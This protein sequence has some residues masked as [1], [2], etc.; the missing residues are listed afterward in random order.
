MSSRG[1]RPSPRCSLGEDVRVGRYRRLALNW[2]VSVRQPFLEVR[3]GE[4]PAVH[5]DVP[6]ADVDRL[7]LDGDDALHERDAWLVWAFEGRDLAASRLADVVAHALPKDAVPG[8]DGGLHRRRGHAV[9]AYEEDPR[10]DDDRERG[11]HGHRGPKERKRH[12]GRF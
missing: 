9:E 11:H 3:L 8:L 10:E 12:L 2:H 6:V 5:E 7:P 1:C 4:L